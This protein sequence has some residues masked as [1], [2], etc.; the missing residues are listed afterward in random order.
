MACPIKWW[1]QD[2]NL[3]W[4]Q[5]PHS[6]PLNSAGGVRWHTHFSPMAGKGNQAY[7]KEKMRKNRGWSWGFREGAGHYLSESFHGKP[8]L[9]A[10]T[11]WLVMGHRLTHVNS[12]KKCTWW[13]PNYLQPWSPVASPPLLNSVTPKFKASYKPL[14][15]LVKKPKYTFVSYY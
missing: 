5:S 9:P 11:Q 3:S 15:E 2:S 13:S 8:E 7:G 1:N 12:R 14:T 4:P 6:Q 10:I